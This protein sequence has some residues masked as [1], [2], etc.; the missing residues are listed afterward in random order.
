MRIFLNIEHGRDLSLKQIYRR[1][2]LYHF[3]G[4]DMS[5][6]EFLLL[7]PAFIVENRRENVKE[8]VKSARQLPLQMRYFKSII[9][10]KRMM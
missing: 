10:K 6:E 9:V 3:M 4:L 7:L 8:R 1:K 5:S 2:S